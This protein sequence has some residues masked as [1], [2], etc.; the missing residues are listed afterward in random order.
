MIKQILIEIKNF[1]GMFITIINEIY[2]W[3]IFKF[4]VSGFFSGERPALLKGIYVAKNFNI[5]WE[6][7]VR[8]TWISKKKTKEI[9]T[10]FV[11]DHIKM[12]IDQLYST[13]FG[14]LL[15]KE[16]IEFMKLSVD[17]LSSIKGMVYGD[18]FSETKKIEFKFRD[19]IRNEKLEKLLS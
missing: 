17:K 5:E 4:K 12:A 10:E 9:T 19:D 16:Y 11:N 2:W 6:I 8:S 15:T 13:N 1:F 14:E 7:W 18:Y 3:R